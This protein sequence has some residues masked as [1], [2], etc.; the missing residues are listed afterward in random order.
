MMHYL[1]TILRDYIVEL[2]PN[3]LAINCKLV[4]KRK[5]ENGIFLRYKARLVIKGCSQ[6]KGIVYEKN[7]F[8]CGSLYVYSL[9]KFI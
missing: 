9:F 8:T 4:F 2:P 3:K 1:L 5:Y 6:Q 7:V